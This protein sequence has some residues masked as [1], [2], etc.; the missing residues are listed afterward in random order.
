MSA[1]V[2]QTGQF[3]TSMAKY[4]SL[5][6]SWNLTCFNL[7]VN[8]SSNHFVRTFCKSLTIQILCENLSKRVKRLEVR[9]IHWFRKTERL[10]E[11]L[12]LICRNLFQVLYLLK[13]NCEH[14]HLLQRKTYKHTHTPTKFNLRFYVCIFFPITTRLL[15]PKYSKYLS[16]TNRFL[17]FSWTNIR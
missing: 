13:S 15:M 3:D 16:I 1:A 6:I 14:N 17:T 10:V 5:D 2:R 8:D 12:E 4:F 11:T 7:W 9:K